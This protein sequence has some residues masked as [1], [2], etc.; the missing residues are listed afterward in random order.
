MA[1]QDL[2]FICAHEP[3]LSGTSDVA[4]RPEFA[5]RRTTYNMDD[6]DRCKLYRNNKQKPVERLDCKRPIPWLA[7]SKI[8]TPHPPH[9]PASVYPPPLVREEDTLAGWRRGWGVNM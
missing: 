3:W 5:D 7:S 4:E 8:L 6:D 2:E 1:A 9:R